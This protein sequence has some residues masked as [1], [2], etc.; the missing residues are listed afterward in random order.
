MQLI[1]RILE[2]EIS[3]GY[4]NW[5]LLQQKLEAGLK[6]VDN[7][8]E[9]FVEETGEKTKVNMEDAL[10]FRVTRKDGVFCYKVFS[11]RFV[12]SVHA[13]VKGGLYCKGLQIGVYGEDSHP[14]FPFP[15]RMF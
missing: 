13:G 11:P 3:A 12:G 8:F 4:I 2:S 7:K 9:A 1:K 5:E 10:T 14:V 15:V 6:L